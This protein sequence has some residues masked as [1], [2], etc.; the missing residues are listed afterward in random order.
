M[1]LGKWIGGIVGFM[2]M[3]PLGALAGYALGSL[4]DN[5]TS[6]Q[7]NQQDINNDQQ[8]YDNAY[9]VSCFPCWFWHHTSSVLTERLC[10]AKWSTCVAFSEITSESSQ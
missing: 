7:D 5:A 4:F 2:S 8:T 10:T 6:K 3:G 1:G 9:T